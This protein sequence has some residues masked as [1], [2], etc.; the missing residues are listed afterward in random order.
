ML[1]TIIFYEIDEFCKQFEST[2]KKLLIQNVA[3]K[4]QRKNNLSMSEVM[5]I[6]VFFH[7]SVIKNLKHII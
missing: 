1:L 7:H 5:T 2:L 3:Q 4:R 6:S